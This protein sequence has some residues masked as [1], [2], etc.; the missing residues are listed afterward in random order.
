MPRNK[1]ISP[2]SLL[3]SIFIDITERK[4]VEESLSTFRVD[5]QAAELTIANQQTSDY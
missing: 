3:F 2:G 4:Q 1:T 5:Q